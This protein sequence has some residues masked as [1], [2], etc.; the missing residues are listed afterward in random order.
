MGSSEESV[1]LKSDISDFDL[2]RVIPNNERTKYLFQEH[3]IRYL[4]ASQFISSKTVL[5]AACGSGY[6]SAILSES[7]ATKV[8][9]ID[10][11]SEAIEYCEKNYKNENLEFK[12]TNC[13]EITLDTTFDVVVSFETIEHLKNQDNFLTEVKRVL[14]DDGI[15]IVSTPNTDTYPSGNPFHHK[16]FTES[17][18]KLFLGKYFSNI[19]LF[20]QF[21][22]SSMAI[23]KPADIMND[24]KINFFNAENS[25]LD[26]INKKFN[27]SNSHGLFFIA[28]CSNTEIKNIENKLYLYR[29]TTNELSSP[30][31]HELSHMDELRELNQK[32]DENLK[33]FET[34]AVSHMD[35]LRE[36]N[37]KKDDNL[38]KFEQK[39][40]SHMDEL[41]ELNQ[42]KDENLKTFETRAVSH[43]DELRE[44]NQKKDDDLKHLRELNKKKDEDLEH[45]RN[46]IKEIHESSAWK[47][48]TKLDFLK[49][50]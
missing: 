22:P 50:D 5:D 35:E 36:L 9:G 27:L 23:S 39:M 4:F 37:K 20:Y 26:D 2:E 15:F 28:L 41:R 19:T 38:K 48:I 7:G 44:L 25:R 16:E 43:M 45:L 3:A 32:K 42:K 17:E 40:G 13:E 46:I 18:F 33:T 6:G 21:Y 14:K 29:D 24:L 30:E 1:D 12:K 8:V 10:N 31:Q 47:L 34:M 11:S 49:K